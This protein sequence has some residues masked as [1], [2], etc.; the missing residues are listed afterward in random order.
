MNDVEKRKVLLFGA[1]VIGA[2]LAH[3]LIQAGN[4][5]TILAREERAKSLSQNG[6]VIK[7]HLQRKTTKD[8]VEAVTDVSGRSFDAAFVVM[9]FHKIR[10]ALPQIRQLDTK[11]LVLVGNDLAPAEIEEDLRKAPGIENI[12]F[13]FQVS[14]GKKETDHYVCERFGG[15]Y[16]DIGRL[17]GK[18]D[19][20]LREWTEKLFE[21]TSYKL[22]WQGD[23][24]AYLICHPAAILPIGYLSYICDGDLRSSTK[25]QRRMMVDA[26]HEAFEALK[27]KGITIYPEGDD[28]FYENGARGKLMQV[29]YLIMSKSRIGD[30]IAC[31]HCR[32]AVSEMEQIDAFYEDLLKDYP[33]EKLEVWNSLRGMMPSWD[34][35]H[36]KYGN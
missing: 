5:V 1:G 3:V 24:E 13:G 35:L 31:E 28:K 23:M 25:E 15:S 21:G 17:H 32:N 7:H 36:R 10:Q 34:E 33:V 6:L 14:G 19:P 11:L 12:L 8:P 26:S 29:L 16:M 18:T 20:E 2:Y 22:N 4:E 30:L 27:A 9:P